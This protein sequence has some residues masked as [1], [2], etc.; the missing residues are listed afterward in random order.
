MTDNEGAQSA[1]IAVKTLHEATYRGTRNSR[2]GAIS[3]HA[4]SA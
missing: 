3:K 1:C 2:E 4:A